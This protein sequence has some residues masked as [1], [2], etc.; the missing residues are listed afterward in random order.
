MIHS[1]TLHGDNL[2]YDTESGALHLFDDEALSILELYE[3]NRG[4]R[5]KEEELNQYPDSWE[6]ADA[7]DQ[8]INRSQLFAARP[9]IRLE[10]LYPEKPRF[11]AMCLNICHDCN[12]RC[13]YCFAES[14]QYGSDSRS[15][16]SA[17]TGMRAVDF[18]ID[19]SGPRRNLDIDF[20][21]G[22]PLMNWEVVKELVAYCEEQGP[23]HGKNIR[24]TITTNALLLNE[25]KINYLN[26]HFKNVVLSCDGTAEN[27]DR[28]RRDAG[29]N[30]TF[31]RIAANIRKF[32]AVRGGKEYYIRGTFTRHNLDFVDDVLALAA[33]GKNVSIEPVVAEPEFEYSIRE[34]DLPQVMRSYEN[35]AFALQADK[36]ASKINFF[37]FNLQTGHD[38][39]I[40][41]RLKGCGAGSEYCA[42][43]PEGYIYPCHQLVGETMHRIGRL[44]EDGYIT[45][46]EQQSAFSEYLM[47]NREPCN[48]CW[49]RY[50]CGGGCA[51]NHWHSTGDL[52]S[53]DPIYCQMLRKRLEC[54][55]WLSYKRI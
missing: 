35:L 42:V 9:E 36:E 21:G 43:T 32:V 40:Y 41:K 1:F 39:C 5:P 6:I 11:K 30:K 16:M 49:A 33:L 2:V 29:G 48:S 23:A 54:A 53:V 55:L 22:E 37:H 12:M 7:L 45:E 31:D 3:K 34:E 27:H 15:S 10:Q 19:A 50:H 28:M 17:K 13:S 26:R 44:T 18:L 51:A 8:L 52:D 38:P 47:P 20:F 25:T 46:P 14:G 4:K 24:L